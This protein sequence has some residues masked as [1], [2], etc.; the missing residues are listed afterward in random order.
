MIE[1]AEVKTFIGVRQAL[2]RK[3]SKGKK[4]NGKTKYGSVYG[5]TLKE[6]REKLYPLKVKYQMIQKDQGES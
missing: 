1:C 3:I 4:A 2:G 6:V 5:K